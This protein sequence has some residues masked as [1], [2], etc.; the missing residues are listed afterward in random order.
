M[1]EL[2]HRSLF[3]SP[4]AALTRTR[5]PWH[6]VTGAGDG[7]A[8]AV[9]DDNKAYIVFRQ[10]KKERKKKGVHRRAACVQGS[11]QQ[12]VPCQLRALLK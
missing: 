11:T 6:A 10:K 9:E 2:S 7:G 12:P 4:W 8:G 5:V 1:I 3:V